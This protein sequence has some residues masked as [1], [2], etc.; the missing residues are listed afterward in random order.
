MTDPERLVFAAAWASF[1]QT[2]NGTPRDFCGRALDAARWAVQCLRE[3]PL[4]PADSR[5]PGQ[6]MLAEF[7]TGDDRVAE[8]EARQA[9]HLELIRKL[10]QTVPL[11]SE[12]AEALE[13]RGALL[14][15]IG[16]LRAKNAELERRVAGWR[17]WAADEIRRTQQE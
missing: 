9:E 13:Q 2:H 15:E 6:R 16:T 1:C 5:T 14:A 7:R 3:A 8:L 4:G 17:E 12:I 10:S 11:E